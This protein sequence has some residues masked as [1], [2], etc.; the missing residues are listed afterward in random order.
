[1][2]HIHRQT[3]TLRLPEGLRELTLY[4][5]PSLGSSIG[6]RKTDP[7]LSPAIS[8]IA[9]DVP[10]SPQRCGRAFRLHRALEVYSPPVCSGETIV[11]W[12]SMENLKE[13]RFDILGITYWM[14]MLAWRQELFGF[15]GF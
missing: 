8:F 15:A 11:C 3:G 13:H 2:G 1:M 5:L 12:W 7:C 4:D 9:N 10:H 6:T 14:L